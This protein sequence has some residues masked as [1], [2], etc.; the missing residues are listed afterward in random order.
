MQAAKF[1]ITITGRI[2]IQFVQDNKRGYK[3][4]L[5]HLR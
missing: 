4:F 2:R 3:K 1:E 5:V